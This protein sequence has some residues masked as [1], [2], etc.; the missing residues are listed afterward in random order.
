ME[1]IRIVLD[2]DRCAGTGVCIL[3]APRVFDQ[4]AAEILDVDLPLLEY[5]V[6]TIV[7]EA[8]SAT[9]FIFDDPSKITDIRNIRFMD[10]AVDNIESYVLVKY[11]IFDCYRMDW[12][13][14]FNMMLAGLDS[15]IKRKQ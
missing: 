11:G 12:N 5:P 8:A 9:T 1:N 3:T 6:A 13:L 15:G 10:M 2:L 4:S 14:H 7:S